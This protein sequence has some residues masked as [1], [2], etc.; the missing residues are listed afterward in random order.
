MRVLFRFAEMGDKLMG[1]APEL[2]LLEIWK[3]DIPYRFF[4]DDMI[5][6]EVFENKEFKE[7][8]NSKNVIEGDN[9]L[10]DCHRFERDEKGVY[11][12]VWINLINWH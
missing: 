3:Y 11:Q 1:K 10:V 9:P 6:R 2:E 5:M 12:T 4:D 7:I 8:I